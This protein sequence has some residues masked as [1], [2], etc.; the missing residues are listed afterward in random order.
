MNFIIHNI[1]DFEVR[2]CSCKC[3]SK[4]KT[5]GLGMYLTNLSYLI[6]LFLLRISGSF[7]T[8]LP[9]YINSGNYAEVLLLALIITSTTYYC[10]Q[11]AVQNYI[12]FII[13]ICISTYILEI[14]LTCTNY[15]KRFIEI[16]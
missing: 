4:S 11:P 2:S 13:F 9:C 5:F 1:S 8:K 16:F 10:N 12:A 14:I 15:I 6:F 7:S 3:S